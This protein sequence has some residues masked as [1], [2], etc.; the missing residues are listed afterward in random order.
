[1]RVTKT[2]RGFTIVELLVVMVII[3]MLIALLMP[4]MNSAREAARRTQ[5]ASNLRQIGLGVLQFEAATKKL[6]NG[7]EG[8]LYPGASYGNSTT[9]LTV[10]AV[11]TVFCDSMSGGQ[12]Y[13]PAEAHVGPF[14]QILPYLGEQLNP[15]DCGAGYRQTADNFEAAKQKVSLYLCPSNTMATTIKD[16]ADCG[17]LDMF[18]TVYTDI[19]GDEANSA[20]GMRNEK[21]WLTKDGVVYDGVTASPA[22]YNRVNGAL[23]LP[24]CRL[25]QISDGVSQT[26]MIV[27]DAG[28]N[29]PGST[30][31]AFV[32]TFSKYPDPVC[33]TA[34]LAATTTPSGTGVTASA[35]CAISPTC[36]SGCTIPTGFNPVVSGSAASNGH[37]V[38]RWADPD[39]GGSG[40]S[41]P[42]AKGEC[43]GTSPFACGTTAS[44]S[45]ALR[46]FVH[47]VNNSNSGSVLTEGPAS[48]SWVI[49]GNGMNDEPFSFHPNGCNAVYVDGSVH[50]LGENIAP[51]VMRALVD[52]A[53][54]I[55][56]SGEDLP[57]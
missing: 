31:G 43:S 51:V 57:R 35:V 32:R 49:N 27:E 6:P 28:R 4:A 26:M 42:P 54:G 23:A 25:D 56:I 20:Y 19:I 17:K 53:G 22:Q 10:T 21:G 14:A 9:P 11:S 15:L 45:S 24:A 34:G 13:F 30:G 50:F 5:C 33:E 16:P 8:Q 36:G 37:T 12:Y 29:Q 38:S 47:W 52:R 39:A 41:G 46:P 40:V 48:A 18:A 1:M 2:R 55:R 44:F 3:A 7:G